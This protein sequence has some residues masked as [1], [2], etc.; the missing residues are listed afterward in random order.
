MIRLLLVEDNERLQGA[1]RAGLEATGDVAVVHACASGE[2]SASS[3]EAKSRVPD[4]MTGCPGR[5]FRVAGFGVISVSMN[6]Q[7]M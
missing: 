7:G 6:M 1:L 4:V 5:N 2:A 3:G